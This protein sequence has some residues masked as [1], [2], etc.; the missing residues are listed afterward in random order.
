MLVFKIFTAIGL[1]AWIVIGIALLMK[2][3]ALFGP[4]RNHQSETPGERSFGISQILAVWVGG[5]ALAIYFLCQ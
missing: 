4:D 1:V 5:F 3:R 2:G